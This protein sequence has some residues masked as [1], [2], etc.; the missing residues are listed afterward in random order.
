VAKSKKAERLGELAAQIRVCARRRLHESRTQAVPG[1]GKYTG[2]VAAV[3][4]HPA[5][6][7]YR[8]DTGEKVREMKRL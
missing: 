7:F 2:R 3:G 4:Y 1:D 6:R 8:E 5:V